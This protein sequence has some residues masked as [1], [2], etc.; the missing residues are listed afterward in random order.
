MGGFLLGCWQYSQIKD[1]QLVLLP[2]DNTHF[3]SQPHKSKTRQHQYK[4]R[5]FDNISG[6]FIAATAASAMIF[7]VT[8]L[9]FIYHI[10][11]YSI[12]PV[13]PRTRLEQRW[14]DLG[15]TILSI[16]GFHIHLSAW[17]YC[18]KPSSPA[19]V[20]SMYVTIDNHSPTNPVP[21]MRIK[22]LTFFLLQNASEVKLRIITI[23]TGETSS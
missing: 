10:P 21:A 8:K 18:M 1:G 23:A 12:I 22:L 14:K 5:M 2:T 9:R 13:E 19:P 20:F 16:P 7:G 6:Y 4:N 11:N 17:L 3:C 15:H